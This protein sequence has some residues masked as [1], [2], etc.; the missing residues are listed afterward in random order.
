MNGLV[1]Q[2]SDKRAQR[3]AARDTT[4]RGQKD[5]CVI[6]FPRMNRCSLLASLALL[7]LPELV[8][9]TFA[10]AQDAESPLASWNVCTTTDRSKPK[11][12]PTEERIA[13]WRSDKATIQR[14]A[15]LDRSPARWEAR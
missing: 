5:E 14:K 8:H 6:P 15:G 13:T 3:V 9:S 1:E 12:V 11:F 10:L 2:E 7:P 4:T